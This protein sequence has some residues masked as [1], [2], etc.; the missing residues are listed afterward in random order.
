[1]RKLCSVVVVTLGVTGC[2]MVAGPPTTQIQINSDPSG[3]LAQLPNGQSCTTPCGL[4]VPRNEAF[5]VTFSKE[6]FQEQTVEVQPRARS[7]GSLFGG[8][9]MELTPNPVYAKLEP[10]SPTRRSRRQPKQPG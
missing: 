2:A 10:A 1:M 8:P 9:E 5:S 4:T 3:A 7:N 6:G